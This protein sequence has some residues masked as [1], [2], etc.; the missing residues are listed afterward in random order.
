RPGLSSFSGSVGALRK[1]YGQRSFDYGE[2]AGS[3]SHRYGVND[4][5]TV[6]GHVE[7]SS[8]VKTAG[9]GSTLGLWQLGT[10]ELAYQQSSA[11]AGSGSSYSAGYQ[12]RG[13]DVNF[14]GRYERRSA[15]FS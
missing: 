9:V 12:Y 10:L 14:G 6:G 7:L 15:G 8:S 5:L 2:L 11:K 4:W 3:A 13:R 1:N